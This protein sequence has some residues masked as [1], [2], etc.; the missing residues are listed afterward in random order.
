MSSKRAYLLRNR[1]QR[2]MQNRMGR[3]KVRAISQV[4]GGAWWV[5][6][7]VFEFLGKGL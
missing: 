6:L 4:L 5:F 2:K 7:G 3:M 1:Q